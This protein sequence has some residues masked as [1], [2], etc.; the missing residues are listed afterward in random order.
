MNAIKTQ[1]EQAPIQQ[2]PP[3]ASM[4]QEVN[5]LEQQYAQPAVVPPYE[6]REGEENYVSKDEALNSAEVAQHYADERERREA[7]YV[8]LEE[9]LQDERVVAHYQAVEVTEQARLAEQQANLRQEVLGRG[10]EGDD[11]RRRRRIGR[12]VGSV[13]K[14]KRPSPERSKK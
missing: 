3:E 14:A 9:A 6:R 2:Y 7:N 5:A 8:S 4:L 13:L 10:N 12:Q 1:H 11:Y